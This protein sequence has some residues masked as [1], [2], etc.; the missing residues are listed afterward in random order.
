MTRFY[1]SNRASKS[2]DIVDEE[3][4]SCKKTFRY[5]KGKEPVKK[6]FSNVFDSARGSDVDERNKM[7]MP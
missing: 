2:E 3:N 4:N 5:S 1:M 7:C 6:Y